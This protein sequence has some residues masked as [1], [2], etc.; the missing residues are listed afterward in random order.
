MNHREALPNTLEWRHHAFWCSAALDFP[1]IATAC[2][3]QSQS[4][5]PVNTKHAT[6]QKV[7]RSFLKLFF[8]VAGIAFLGNAG[9][10][11]PFSFSAGQPARASEVNANFKN[12]DDRLNAVESS[13][14]T[15]NTL[16]IE[17]THPITYSYVASTPGYEFT[18][19]GKKYRII[20]V[21]IK[22]FAGELYA[23]T[24]PA[25]V[26]TDPNSGPYILGYQ[27]VGIR[28]NMSSHLFKQNTVVN[29]FAAQIFYSETGYYNYG[30]DWTGKSGIGAY[31]DQYLS[32]R[33][34]WYAGITVRVADF[35]VDV[36]FDSYYH[37]IKITGIANTVS[38]FTKLD[39]SALDDGAAS[40]GYIDQLID[41][42][43]VERLQ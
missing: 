29:G 42:V 20:R 16:T 13:G 6:A 23:V 12:L 24:Y 11:V 43:K 33:S 3:L 14:S 31:W 30:G 41:Y 5:H 7:L 25:E 37:P 38:D 28:T 35:Y 22:G 1:P 8:C 15:Q 27:S 18:L 21:P 40:L 32:A 9:A 19:G 39:L 26:K 34:N 17:K 2:R 4:G 36:S 10:A